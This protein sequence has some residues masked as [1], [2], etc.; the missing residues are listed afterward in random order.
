MFVIMVSLYPVGTLGP[1]Y[2][3]C[4][5]FAR[6]AIFGGLNLGLDMD[7]WLL[8][9]VVFFSGHVVGSDYNTLALMQQLIITR[10][11]FYCYDLAE[12]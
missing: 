2:E 10:L 6:P 3:S 7:G 12:F 9:P 1:G 4:L 5:R 8:A 11:L